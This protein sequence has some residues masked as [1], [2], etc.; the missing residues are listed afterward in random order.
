MQHSRLSDVILCVCVCVCVCVRVVAEGGCCQCGGW[1]APQ[2]GCEGR[3][4]FERGHC[5]TRPALFGFAGQMFA[6]Q[7]M[8]IA[9]DVGV[10]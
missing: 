8:Q 4:V 1:G 3:V 2:C 6:C 7:R 10:P 9:D 5:S